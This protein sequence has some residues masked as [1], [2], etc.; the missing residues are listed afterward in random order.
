MEGT[1][2]DKILA[3]EI[4]ADV[5]YETEDV[6]AFRDIAPVAPTHVLVIPKIRIPKLGDAQPDHEVLLGRLILCL[7]NLAHLIAAGRFDL[8]HFSARICQQLN[9]KRSGYHLGEIE[10]PVSG[11]R[12]LA[13]RFDSWVFM[14]KY[15]DWAGIQ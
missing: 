3:R 4:P 1:I 15:G 11:V 8:D 14:G 9:G 7:E 5:V 2:F 12:E 6:L 13:H 10:Y